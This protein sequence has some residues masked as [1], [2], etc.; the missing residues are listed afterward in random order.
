MEEKE[1]VLAIEAI[2]FASDQAVS[3]SFLHQVLNQRLGPVSSE[4]MARENGEEATENGSEEVSKEYIQEAIN[5]LMEKYTS[6]DFSFELIYISEG[7]Q[8]F[9]KPIFHSYVRSATLQNNK[10]KLSKAALETLSI[11]AYKQPITKAEM[12]FIRGVNCDYSVQKLLEKKLVDIV[13]RSEAPGK[14]LLYGTSPF[15]M[16]YFGL[17]SIEELPKL[18]EFEPSEDMQLNLFKL[19]SES[20]EIHGEETPIESPQTFL[21]GSNGSREE[22]QK[23]ADE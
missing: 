8:F 2:I 20:G 15:F 1:I 12:E 18:K 10:K 19:S 5:H 7:Y 4:K 11:I 6:T 17:G 14:P 16:Q 22:A 13:G 21:E 9:T 3:I 23:K